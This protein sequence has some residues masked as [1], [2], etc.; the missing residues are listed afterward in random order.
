[1]SFSTLEESIEL[2]RPILLYRA[3]RE[4]KTWFYCDADREVLYQD[5]VY[6]PLPIFS[7]S[8]RATGDAKSDNV[9]ITLPSTAELSIYLDRYPI[10]ATVML[11]IFRVH[12]VE[13]STTGSITV[14]PLLVDA[15]CLWVGELSSVQRP[16]Q[17]KRVLVCSTLSATLLRGGVRLVW[18][19]T[20]PHM[21]YGR[22]CL[23]NKDD[24]QQALSD[25]AVV[26]GVT[27]SSD[28][29]ALHED[30]WFSGG[31]VVWEDETG[32]YENRGIETHAGSSITI[33]GGTRGMDGKSGFIAYP[34]C[35][36]IDTVCDSKFG[37][38]LN[39]GGINKMQGKSP[40]DGFPVY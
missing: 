32:I 17:L 3:A 14:E 10:S 11:S 23:V 2:G 38:I 12:A 1:M 13:N 29:L 19:R 21:L 7:T 37:N 31:F 33:F 8:I 26:N 25:V 18:E 28:D 39:Y 22:G 35:S 9:N 6:S 15:K 40:F 36:R 27:I 16:S 4:T 5:N 24:F 20:C 30:G 34:G